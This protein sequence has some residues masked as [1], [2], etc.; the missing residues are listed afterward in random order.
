MKP[1]T[2]KHS[3]AAGSPLHV[4]GSKKETG[5]G[6]TMF[7]DSNNDGTMLSRG[8]RSFRNYVDPS[9]KNAYRNSNSSRQMFD[10]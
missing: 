1:F 10:L 4:G 9:A 5:D 3:I 7:N 6:D 2:N 8:L